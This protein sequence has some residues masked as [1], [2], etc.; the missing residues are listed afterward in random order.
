[1]TINGEI[2]LAILAA[3]A[4]LGLLS[5]MGAYIVIGMAWDTSPLRSASGTDTDARE[6]GSQLSGWSLTWRALKLRCPACGRGRIFG[7][8][9]K[10]NQVCGSCGRTFWKSEGE[11]LGPAVVDYSMATAGA[12]VAWALMVLTGLSET[13]QLLGAL[14]AALAVAA[15]SSRWSRSFWTLLL[16]VSGELGPA[17]RDISRH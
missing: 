5:L 16:Y 4:V 8:Y 12:L 6:G 2:A 13:A 3:F 1:M 15:A 11:W 9:F 14:I 7:T 17:L 10:M